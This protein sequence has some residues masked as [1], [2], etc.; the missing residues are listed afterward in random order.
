MERYVFSYSLNE[1]VFE[2]F[3]SD[4]SKKLRYDVEH[5]L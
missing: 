1:V 5:L 2:L 3:V 4:I